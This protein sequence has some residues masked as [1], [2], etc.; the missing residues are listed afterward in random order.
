MDRYLSPVLFS[1][2]VKKSTG[3]STGAVYE[4]TTAKLVGFDEGW[5][6]NAIG[7]DPELVVAPCRQAGLTDERW[8]FWAREFE[9]EV[10]AIDILLI[11]ESGRVGV[12][13]TKLAYNPE[14]RRSVLAQLL[15]Y[16]VHLGEV[17]PSDLPELPADLRMSKEEVGRRILD[18]RDFLLIVAGD[19][20]NARAVKLGRTLLGDHLM[21]QWELALV[22]VSVFRRVGAV[23]SPEHLLVPHIR[24]AIETELR[25]IVKVTVEGDRSR[26]VVE[27]VEPVSSSE[28]AT[29][30]NEDSFLVALDQAPQMQ[31]AKN[32]GTSLKELERTHPGTHVRWGTGKGASA[33]LKR[34]G[35][36]LIEIYVGWGH[37]VFAKDPATLDAALGKTA[38]RLWLDGLQQLLPEQMKMTKPTVR[39]S[40]PRLS[41]VLDLTRSVLRQADLVGPAHQ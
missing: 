32:L 5:L 13:E 26:V 29:Q 2:D 14:G 40:E 28:S 33:L 31:A 34:N 4:Q 41:D 15:D 1:A 18:D 6:Q 37:V 9:V 17:E 3:R 12:V 39:G 8:W 10:G 11:S 38:A 36:T 27:R 21:N 16:A 20:L 23:G 25:Q 22:E 24:G 19:E 35:R 7:N 30:W